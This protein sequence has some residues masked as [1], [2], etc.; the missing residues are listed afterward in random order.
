M[1]SSLILGSNTK[2]TD[3]ISTGISSEKI[4]PFDTGLEPTR[5]NLANG[6]V[7]LKFYNS[8]LVQKSISSMHS[9]FS[10]NIV[11]ELNNWSRILANNFT[12]KTFLFGT[13]KSVRIAVKSKFTYNGRGIAFHGE[14][15]RSFGNDFAT[16]VVIFGVENSLSS[17]T[18][19]QKN[20]F[21]VFGAGLTQGIN[22]STGAAGKKLVLTLVKK[23]QNFT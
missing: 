22:D 3:W 6:I 19:N 12:L 7:N 17:H 9:Y 18:D 23:I 8:V 4:K 1:L 2:V 20:N 15:S 14:G 5:S 13:V 11:Y 10:L 16:N 21:L